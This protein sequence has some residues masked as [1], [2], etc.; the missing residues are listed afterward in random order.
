MEIGNSRKIY[1][2]AKIAIKSRKIIPKGTLKVSKLK[3]SSPRQ[4]LTTTGT[5]ANGILEIKFLFFQKF[6]WIVLCFLRGMCFR[7]IRIF[8]WG[9]KVWTCWTLFKMAIFWIAHYLLSLALLSFDLLKQHIQGIPSQSGKSNLALRE[10]RKYISDILWH[11][12]SRKYWPILISDLVF[13]KNKWENMKNHNNCLKVDKIWK[14]FLKFF[15]NFFS[16][17]THL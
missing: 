6:D 9:F 10:G 14:L 16:H 17:K 15:W 5:D 12:F 1:N 8:C 11:F 4:N 7:V 13:I 2:F 3:F